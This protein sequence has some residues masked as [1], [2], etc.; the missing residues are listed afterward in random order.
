MRLP[1][2]LQTL[3]ALGSNSPEQQQ[4]QLCNGLV[5]RIPTTA[6]TFV[7]NDHRCVEDLSSPSSLLL[8]TK[9]SSNL[10]E[11]KKDVDA[12]TPPS[13]K[14]LQERFG[15][16]DEEL[17]KIF[18]RWPSL[19]TLQISMLQERT[20]WLQKRLSLKDAEVKKLI[21]QFP[22]VLSLTIENNIEPTLVFYQERLGINDATLAKTVK[23]FPNLVAYSIND[24][25]EPKLSWLQQRLN[26][27]EAQLGNLVKK[28]PNILG[29]SIKENM[30]P[31]IDWL[32]KRLNLDK[33]QIGKLVMRFPPSLYLSIGDNLEPKL[34]W[35]Q[36]RLD[37]NDAQVTKILRGRP[38]IFGHAVSHLEPTLTWLQQKLSLDDV[39]LAKLIVALPTLLGCDIETNLSPTLNFYNDWISEDEAKQLVTKNPRMFGASL[40]G[41][42]KPRL[43][44]A[45]ESGVAIDAGCFVRMAQYTEERWQA[46]L[47]FQERKAL[48]ERAW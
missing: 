20:N 16:T 43:E 12:T 48:I 17:K 5:T 29:R 32:Q 3:F 38:Q 24:N 37:L 10:E 45:R 27:T 22:N 36:S 1:F 47:A 21:L 35:L 14:W 8:A 46:S 6:F 2:L 34:D 30:E 40:E 15:V 18:D 39:G 26:M 25:V 9:K 28:Q 4:K 41:R 7:G 44:Q 19:L 33:T 11:I 23:K 13:G 42:L 31:K